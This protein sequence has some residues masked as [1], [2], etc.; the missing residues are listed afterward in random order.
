MSMHYAIKGLLTTLFVGCFVLVCSGCHTIEGAGRDVQ[1]I[2]GAT[3]E[4]AEE[5]RAYDREGRLRN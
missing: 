2:G 3:A 5:T 4:T 1:A